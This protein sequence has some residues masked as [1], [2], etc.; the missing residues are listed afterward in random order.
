MEYHGNFGHTIGFIQKID[1]MSRID[2]C[3]TA[4]RLGTKNVAPKLP[5]F[6]G[7]KICIQYINSNL[8][9]NILY[10]YNSH[11]GS[12]VIILTWGLYQTKDYTTHNGL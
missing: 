4:C 7:I 10:L 5:G 6:Q 8:H 11:E 1:I 2:I 9:K 12:N 3:Y